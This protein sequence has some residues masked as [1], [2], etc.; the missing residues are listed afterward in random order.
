MEVDGNKAYLKLWGEE[1]GKESP[2]PDSAWKCHSKIQFCMC[3]LEH[4]IE[5]RAV[6][7]IMVDLHQLTTN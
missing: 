6:K 1:E 3:Q 2:K 7:D 5:Y 4:K